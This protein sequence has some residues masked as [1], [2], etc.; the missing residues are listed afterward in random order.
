MAVVDRFRVLIPPAYGLAGFNLATW[1]GWGSVTRWNAF[2]AILEMHGKGR[3]YDPRLNNAD[4]FPIAAKNNF[5][6]IQVNP[7]DDRVTPKLAALHFYQ[8]A[9]PAPRPAPN[10]LPYSGQRG[11]ALF[12]GKAQCSRCH[13]PP[14]WTEPGHNVHPPA[15]VCVDDFQ[16]SRSPEKGYRTAPLAGI[17]FRQKGGFYH[18]GRFATLLD[19][20]SHYNDC[21]NLQLTEDEKSDL[22]QY[23]LT[24]SFDCRSI[25]NSNAYRDDGLRHRTRMRPLLR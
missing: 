1:T 12:N 20:V 15:E 3:F 11:A 7:Q 5:G 9:I 24:P 17:F 19:V 8:L 2:V 23:L 14:L 4:Q 25:L 21:G 18:D 16:A 13:V 6:D 22:V 10:P